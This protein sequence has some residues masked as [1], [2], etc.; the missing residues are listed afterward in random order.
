MDYVYHQ[1][2]GFNAS[3]TEGTPVDN[4]PGFES[5]HITLTVNPG[6]HFSPG[7]TFTVYVNSTNGIKANCGLPGT[8]G[9]RAHMSLIVSPSVGAVTV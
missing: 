6:F 2:K 4:E 8:G 3:W 9:L 7:T 1:T 5:S